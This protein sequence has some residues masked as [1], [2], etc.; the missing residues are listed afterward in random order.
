MLP[1]DLVRDAEQGVLEGKRLPGSY[2]KIVK[3][4]LSLGESSRLISW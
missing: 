1:W 2:R 4:E 3:S